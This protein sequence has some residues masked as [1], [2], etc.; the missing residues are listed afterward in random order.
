MN[1]T[2]IEQAD[3]DST[4]RELS[5]GGLGIVV[6]LTVFSGIIFLSGLTSNPAGNMY[7]SG[8]Y[9]VYWRLV[10]SSYTH[11]YRKKLL[12]FPLMQ[13]RHLSA[14]YWCPSPVCVCVTGLLGG[15]TCQ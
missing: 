11:M 8:G 14:I 3:L 1:F 12:V 5:N 4:R 10:S 2:K 9:D 15:G 6:V 7:S 13:P